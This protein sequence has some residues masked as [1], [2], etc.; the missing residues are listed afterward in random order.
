MSVTSTIA[1]LVTICEEV[2]L[3]EPFAVVYADPRDAGVI[4]AFPA[5]IWALD[6]TVQHVWWCEAAGDPGLDRHTYTLAGYLFVGS[7]ATGLAELHSRVLGWL[8]PSGAT[9]LS[10]PGVL[11]RD[12]T[13][14]GAVEFLGTPDAELFR[15][16]IGPMTWARGEYFGV[17]LW[18]PVTEKYP[19]PPA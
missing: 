18:L 17:R 10:L 19:T 13:L 8:T 1:A 5:L 2:V 12:L 9:G 7:R 16:T 6:P 15:Y 14:N 4:G 3:P 11:R